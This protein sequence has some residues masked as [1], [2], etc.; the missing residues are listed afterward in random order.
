VVSGFGAL[1]ADNA[2][3][4][5]MEWVAEGL[6]LCFIGVLAALITTTIGSGQPATA[7]VLRACAGMLVALS[8][9]SALTGARTS[10]LP[11]KLCPYVKIA[12][13]GMFVVASMS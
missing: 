6:T 2:R 4:I 5:T 13:A 11:M 7:V 8:V 3:I 12:V 10:L 9:L 1:T